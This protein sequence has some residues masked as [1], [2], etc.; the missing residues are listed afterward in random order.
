MYVRIIIGDQVVEMASQAYIVS[1]KGREITK[2]A[3]FKVHYSTYLQV[4]L[5][6]E[7]IYSWNIGE[8]QDAAH[9]PGV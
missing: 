4:L 5:S 1:V 7:R 6:M 3:Q 2:C 9:C 8:F